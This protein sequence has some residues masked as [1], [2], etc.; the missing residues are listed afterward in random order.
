[1][2]TILIFF[3]IQNAVNPSQIYYYYDRVN[4]VVTSLGVFDCT[5]SKKA[6]DIE[7]DVM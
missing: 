4:D 1:M 3:A 7:K 2:G 6:I 5:N